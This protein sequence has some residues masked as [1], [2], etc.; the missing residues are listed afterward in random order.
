MQIDLCVRRG[1][2]RL[3]GDMTVLIT[4]IIFNSIMALVVGSVFYNLPNTTGALY[5]RGA[6]LFFGIQLAAFASALEVR[7]YSK[8]KSKFIDK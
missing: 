5:G 6:L 2:Q 4:G 1:Y 3:R 8:L 7:W